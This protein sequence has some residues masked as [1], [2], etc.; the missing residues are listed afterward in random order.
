M[1]SPIAEA[2]NGAERITGSFVPARTLGALGVGA[3]KI[4][5]GL[6]EGAPARIAVALDLTL[7][8]QSN[9]VF[10]L[11]K[12]RGVCRCETEMLSM[13]PSTTNPAVSGSPPIPGISPARAR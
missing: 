1:E 3:D 4:F 2:R 5:N 11:V 12:P 10:N 13:D 6:I 8:E 9:T 7:G